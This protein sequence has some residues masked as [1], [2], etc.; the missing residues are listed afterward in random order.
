MDLS[1]KTDRRR[2]ENQTYRVGQLIPATGMYVA[3]HGMVAARHEITLR[4]GDTFPPCSQCGN[5]VVFR[6]IAAA[7]EQAALRFK[8]SLYVIPHPDKSES[9]AA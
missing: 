3:T 9:Q 8:I 5:D 2:P 1:L 7:E 4:L 6:L